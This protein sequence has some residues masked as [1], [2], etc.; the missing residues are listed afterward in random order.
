MVAT[1]E[2]EGNIV[3][4][5]RVERGLSQRR[6]TLPS[7][8]EGQKVPDAA[9][10]RGHSSQLTWLYFFFF[11]EVIEVALRETGKESVEME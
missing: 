8:E 7:L 4:G 6:V 11:K 5:E 2:T 9:K 10:S 1:E 3:K